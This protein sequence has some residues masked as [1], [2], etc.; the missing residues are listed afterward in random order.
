MLTVGPMKRV[1]ITGAS[2]GLGRGL[3]RLYA[4]TGSVIGLVGRREDA[5]RTLAAELERRGARSEIYPVDVRSTER[6]E[7]AS[8]HFFE[9]AG[10]CDV[11][12]ANAG[13]GEARKDLRCDSGAAAEVMHVNVIGLTNTLLPW[14]DR[15]R[16]Q[17]SGTLVGMASVAGYRAI[18]GSLSYSAS[19][20]AVMTFMEGLQ[21]ELDGSGVHAMSICPGFI[22]TP[23][24]DKNEF[25][26]PFLM[27]CDEACPKMKKAIDQKRRRYTFPFPMLVAAQ[28]MRVAPP[29]FLK[30]ISPRWRSRS[31]GI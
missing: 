13:I 12:I 23:L 6:M 27:E 15:M 16:T 19:K 4:E 20:A 28:M 10:G 24:T 1:F 30:R 14:V 21:M 22:R 11:V 2:S 26:M 29:W 18:P 8:S 3:A 31:P 9:S 25:S 5:L 17:G 7:A